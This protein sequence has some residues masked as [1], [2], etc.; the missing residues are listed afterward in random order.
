MPAMAVRD[1]LVL[2]LPDALV[3]AE[4]LPVPGDV[5]VEDDKWCGK[6]SVHS[7]QSVNDLRPHQQ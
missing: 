6:W 5:W 3:D 4:W 1:A 2:K 7:L